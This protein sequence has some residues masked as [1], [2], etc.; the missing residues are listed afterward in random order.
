MPQTS[1]AVQSVVSTQS[2]RAKCL[3]PVLLIDDDVVYSDSLRR[4]LEGWGCAVETVSSPEEAESHLIGRCF[5]AIL[6]D[7]V[8]EG[9]SVTGDAF[10]IDN[11]DLQVESKFAVITAQEPRSIPGGGQLDRMN[12]PILEKGSDTYLT[13]LRDI[14]IE[15]QEKEGDVESGKS[16]M[17]QLLRLAEDLLVGWLRSRQE[18]DKKGILYGNKMYSANDLITEIQNGTPVG[19]DHL[20][21]LLEEITAS[22]NITHV[23]KD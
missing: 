10:I 21:M 6:V 8:F 13:D 23:E 7:Y 14:L 11:Q 17:H 2:L 3:S 15:P 18:P 1:S 12:I 5:K 4:T 9:S 22:L 20:A 19:Q 16:G